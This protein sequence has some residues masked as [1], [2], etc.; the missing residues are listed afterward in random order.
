MRLRNYI[1]AGLGLCLFTLAFSVFHY[2]FFAKALL[3]APAFLALM[4]VVVAWNAYVAICRTQVKTSDD[5]MVLR[6]GVKWG[7]AIGCAWA[8]VAIVPVNIFTRNDEL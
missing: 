6:D 8:V 7:L 2:P 5:S 4:I 1:L 3:N